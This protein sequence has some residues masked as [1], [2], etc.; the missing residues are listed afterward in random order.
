MVLEKLWEEVG[1]QVARTLELQNDQMDVVNT[2]QPP[3]ANPQ[4]RKCFIFNVGD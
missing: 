4:A 1:L 3:K 2:T